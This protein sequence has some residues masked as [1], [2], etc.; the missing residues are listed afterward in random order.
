VSGKKSNQEVC[1]VRDGE[2]NYFQ[3]SMV[4]IVFDSGSS[5]I[6]LC[7]EDITDLRNYQIYLEHLVEERTEKLD[8]SNQRLKQKIDELKAVKNDL[9]TSEKRF[10][11]LAKNARD[12]I[13]RII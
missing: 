2:E 3:L 13:Y 9:E 10:R 5:G 4:P 7:F 8:L 6:S 12:I 1:I 11:L